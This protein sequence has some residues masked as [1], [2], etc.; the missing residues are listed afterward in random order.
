[1]SSL[2]QQSAGRNVNPYEHIVIRTYCH[3]DILAY[4][5]IFIRTYWHTDIL[6]YGHIV[7]ILDGKAANTNIIVFGLTR[8]RFQLTIL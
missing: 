6:S 2:K 8:L 5:H 7:L 3:T 1:M 4:G